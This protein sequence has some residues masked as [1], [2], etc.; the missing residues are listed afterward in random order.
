M[1]KT[2]M[3]YLLLSIAITYLSVGIATMVSLEKPCNEIQ[4]QNTIDSLQSELNIMSIEKGRY[5]YMIDIIRNNDSI[6]ID[7]LLKNIE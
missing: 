5:E 1:F 7:S 4:L 3:T 6:K 2:I